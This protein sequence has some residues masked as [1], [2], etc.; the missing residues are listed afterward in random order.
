M[1]FS[2]EEKITELNNVDCFIEKVK[3]YYAGSEISGPVIQVMPGTTN[4][5]KSQCESIVYTLHGV[6]TR[7]S[8]LDLADE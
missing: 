3:I 6:T 5:Y 7:D 4:H 2:K 8:L 1:Q